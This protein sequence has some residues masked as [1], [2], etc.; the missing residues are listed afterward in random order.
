MLGLWE[1]G[2]GPQRSSLHV[3]FSVDIDNL[4]QAAERLRERERH[5]TRL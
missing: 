3:A 4:L 1:A 2:T 5:P